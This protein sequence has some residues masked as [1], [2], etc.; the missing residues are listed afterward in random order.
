MVG[1]NFTL[2][3]ELLLFLL[4]LWGTNRFVLRPSVK[5]I[6]EREALIRHNEASSARDE[7]DAVELELRYESE[8]SRLHRE[9]DE[10]VREARRKALDARLDAVQKE[11]KQA[12]AAIMHYRNEM[13]ARIENQTERAKEMAPEIAA[14]IQRRLREGLSR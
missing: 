13:A 1:I 14:T 3:V 12:D 11:M 2:V 8:L 5:T 10:R 9:A 6:D 4:F 7:Q